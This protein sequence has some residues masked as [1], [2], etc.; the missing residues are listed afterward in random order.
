MQRK[1]RVG[2]MMAAIG[3]PV[4]KGRCRTRRPPGC[5]RE[6][7]AAVRPESCGSVGQNRCRHPSCALRARSFAAP[8]VACPSTCHS[9]P[10]PWSARWWP[11]GADRR[12]ANRAP[13]LASIL[14]VRCHILQRSHKDHITRCHHHPS[15]ISTS[16]LT[17]FATFKYIAV[18]QWVSRSFPSFTIQP[19]KPQIQSKVNTK[20]KIYII[21][22]QSVELKSSKY[23]RMFKL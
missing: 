23:W 15:P 5:C 14:R 7:V 16:L 2:K 20:C 9:C 1:E 10:G 13:I 3:R 18:A 6:A 8:W 17:N 11:T 21:E 22:K 19:R 12:D 4:F